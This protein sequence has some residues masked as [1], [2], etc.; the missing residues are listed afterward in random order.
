MVNTTTY[1]LSEFFGKVQEKYKPPYS[2]LKCQ[3]HVYDNT[4]I[5]YKLESVI[6]TSTSLF[7][8]QETFSSILEIN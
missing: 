1:F 7:L 8:S 4:A 3:N 2:I 6:L 5:K